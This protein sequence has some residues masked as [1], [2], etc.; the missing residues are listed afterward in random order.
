[1]F[2]AKVPTRKFKKFQVDA[3]DENV[4]LRERVRAGATQHP[5]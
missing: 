5:I 3:Y 2:A 1:M 4:N